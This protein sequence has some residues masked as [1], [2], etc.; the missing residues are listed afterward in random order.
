MRLLHKIRHAMS[1]RDSNYQLSGFFE[2]D[3]AYFGVPRPKTDGRGTTKEKVAIALSTNIKGNP[4]V[5]IN[6]NALFQ[7]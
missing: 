1:E 3:D 5:F 4:D 6:I 2:M 7:H